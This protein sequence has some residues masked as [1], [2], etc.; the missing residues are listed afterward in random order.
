[1]KRKPAVWT[2]TAAFGPE[3]RHR[4]KRAA[5]R[6]ASKLKKY[7]FTMVE[8]V[9]PG[10]WGPDLSLIWFRNKNTTRIDRRGLA[11]KRPA[12]NKEYVEWRKGALW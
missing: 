10:S 5:F 6:A 12:S 3:S 11:M 8:L 1:M 4:T 9:Y 7:D 2:V